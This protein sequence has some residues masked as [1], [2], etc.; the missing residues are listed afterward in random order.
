MAALGVE[1][2][3]AGDGVGGAGG[4][5]ARVERRD[6]GVRSGEVCC[7]RG[8]GGA[9]GGAG[10]GAGGAGGGGGEGEEGEGGDFGDR[11]DVVCSWV[12]WWWGG[13]GSGR[14]GG[15]R[16]GVDGD[17]VGDGAGGEEGAFEGVVGWEGRGDADAGWLRVALAGWMPFT[18]TVE[19]SQHV[20]PGDRWRLALTAWAALQPVQGASRREE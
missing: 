2:L 8:G 9:V 14:G 3:E 5:G 6:W 7:R 19:A 18:S 16:G 10:A 4:E 13:G 1:R 15:W 12:G 17:E 11:E 20:R